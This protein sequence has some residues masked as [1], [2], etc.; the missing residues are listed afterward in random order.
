M[1]KGTRGADVGREEK[2]E[3]TFS[4]GI[5]EDDD[6]VCQRREAEIKTIGRVS[7]EGIN[8]NDAV[9]RTGWFVELVGSIDR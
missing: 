8:G 6:E 2:L 3:D 7:V 5:K 1:N 4:R 9:V